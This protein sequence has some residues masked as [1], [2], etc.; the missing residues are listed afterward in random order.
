MIYFFLSLFAWSLIPP[1]PMRTAPAATPAHADSAWVL[2]KRHSQI[3]FQVPRLGFSK[4]TGRF[5]TFEMSV[6]LDA[7]DVTTLQ[8]EA[9]VEV[10]SVDTGIDRR[11][12][13]LRS[14]DFFD[15]AS[16]PYILFVSTAV[17]PRDDG[18][19][20]LVGDLT[21]RGVTRAVTFRTTPLGTTV[22]NDQRRLAFEATAIIDRTV[23]GVSWSRVTDRGGLII[24]NE[25]TIQL[26]IEIGEEGA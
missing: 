1:G 24:G 2:D 10:A 22:W 11:D 3:Q 6:R 7:A 15:A 14:D 4:V 20:D 13:H 5:N 23:Y 9:R 21:L 16:H 8:V 17:M 12:E 25:V 18:T 19:F 26:S